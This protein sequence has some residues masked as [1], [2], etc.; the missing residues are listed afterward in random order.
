VE[1]ERDEQRIIIIIIKNTTWYLRKYPLQ[2][3]KHIPKV[4]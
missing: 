2:K 4:S 1:E 3:G